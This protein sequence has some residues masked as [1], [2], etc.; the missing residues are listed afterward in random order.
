MVTDS[1]V[2][3]P[4]GWRDLT[5]SEA[6]RLLNVYV[7]ASSRYLTIFGVPLGIG[8]Y[9]AVSLQAV[10]SS[11][12]AYLVLAILVIALLFDVSV[13]FRM[14]AVLEWAAYFSRLW[15]LAFFLSAYGIY[16]LGQSHP[17]IAAYLVIGG[18]P[19]L[20]AVHEDYRAIL[21]SKQARLIIDR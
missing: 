13:F 20:L 6:W 16:I 9:F 11:V 10:G 12:F 19:P 21:A 18:V 4:Y 7:W 1:E 8:A 14:F 2:R 17:F 15:H 3:N 5:P